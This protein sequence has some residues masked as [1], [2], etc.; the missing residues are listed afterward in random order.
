MG[1]GE[2]HTQDCPAS[3]PRLRKKHSG[4][5]STHSGNLSTLSR[6]LQKVDAFPA[7][8]VDDLLRNRWPLSPGISGQFGPE[9]AFCPF[10]GRP[11]LKPFSLLDRFLASLVLLPPMRPM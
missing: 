4:K 1:K 5:S 10:A 3:L 7:E 11:P 6:D 9:Y 8:S 2:D